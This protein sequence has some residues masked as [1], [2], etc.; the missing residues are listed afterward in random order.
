MINKWL[1]ASGGEGAALKDA[2]SRL[3]VDMLAQFLCTAAQVMQDEQVPP[4]Q[5]ERVIQGILYANTPQYARWREHE[6]EQ[7]AL[8]DLLEAQRR[9]LVMTVPDRKPGPPKATYT[10]TLTSMSSAER[11]TITHM[12][13]TRLLAVTATDEMTGGDLPII[14]HV[15][16][17]QAV[18][19]NLHDTVHGPRNLVVQIELV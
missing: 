12:L 11:R 1:R 13:G 7:E 17:P 2:A 3:Q 9:P 10:T 14:W 16:S 8:R 5:V 18:S 19:V 15:V 6:R 4:V